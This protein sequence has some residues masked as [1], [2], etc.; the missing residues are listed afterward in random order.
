M[1]D[2]ISNFIACAASLVI[3]AVPDSNLKKKQAEKLLHSGLGIN[4]F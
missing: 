4:N 3:S 2:Y 1:S